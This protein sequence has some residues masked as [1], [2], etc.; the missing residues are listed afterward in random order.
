MIIFLLKEWIPN[1]EE[2]KLCIQDIQ[3]KNFRGIYFY[4]YFYLYTLKNSYVVF[5]N[6]L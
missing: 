3:H 6:K 4:E 5:Q 1:Q 2:N